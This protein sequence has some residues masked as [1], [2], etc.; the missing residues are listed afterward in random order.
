MLGWY[1]QQL[2]LYKQKYGVQLV[3]VIDVHLYPQAANVDTTAE[4]SFT[5]ALRLRSTRAFW[6][7]TYTDESWINQPIMLIPRIQAWIKSY[8]PGLQIAVSEYS[9][10]SDTI[11]TAALAQAMIL[12]IFSKFNVFLGTKWVSPVLNTKLEEGFRIYTNYDGNG[13]HVQGDS[14]GAASNNSVEAEAYA[15]DNNGQLF[16]IIVNK[17]ESPLPV[18]VQTPP[19]KQ[20]KV[21][22]YSFSSTQALGPS[23]TATVSN[24]AFQL[25]LA[26]WSATLAVIISS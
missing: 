11:V 3:D 9:W 26:P 7:P 13:A 22:L 2:G 1:I 19:V 10:G 6:D 23:G 18:I 25:T 20:G 14:V 17:I 8:N 5:A 15:F 12:G 4:D 24:A 16:V 21:S